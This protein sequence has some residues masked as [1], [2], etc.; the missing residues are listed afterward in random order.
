MPKLKKRKSKKSMAQKEKKNKAVD[1][2]F[3]NEAV[4]KINNLLSE[5]DDKR[6]AIGDYIYEKF[7]D[8][9]PE[10]LDAKQSVANSSYAKL[11]KQS[12]LKADRSTLSRM[13][14]V[15]AQEKFFNEHQF[16]SSGLSYNHK[17][18]L[19]KIPVNEKI[20]IAKAGLKE[21]MP[22]RIFVQHIN[23]Y[24]GQHSRKS[25]PDKSQEFINYL[26]RLM[27]G[28]NNK[29]YAY[30]LN[31]SDIG[32]MLKVKIRKIEA[33]D[34]T[35]VAGYLQAIHTALRSYLRNLTRLEIALNDKKKSL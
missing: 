33:K 12:D 11:C 1:P 16:N 15:A 29:N 34:I 17:V 30:A 10:L 8:R 6:M 9:K 24:P 31:K 4:H 25:S 35:T 5:T 13:V 23:E 32:K 22:Y 20:N 7:F 19:L 3:I 21:K 27:N 28:L 18:A 26:R 14:R 2:E